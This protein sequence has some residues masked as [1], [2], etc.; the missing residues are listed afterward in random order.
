MAGE[1]VGRAG[2]KGLKG[3]EGSQEVPTPTTN[4]PTPTFT[5]EGTLSSGDGYEGHSGAR[6]APSPCPLPLP[7]NKVV[8]GGLQFLEGGPCP[9]ALLPCFNQ[10][11]AA[12]IPAHLWEVLGI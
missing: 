6:G 9:P 3:N 5:P 8:H 4:P 12:Q 10:L 2:Q 7:T 11:H 1:K